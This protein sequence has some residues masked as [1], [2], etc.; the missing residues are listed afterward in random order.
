MGDKSSKRLPEVQPFDPSVQQSGHEAKALVASQLIYP[1]L[2]Q[3]WTKSLHQKASLNLRNLWSSII[4]RSDFRKCWER[5]WYR[6][7]YQKNGGRLGTSL[8]RT[9]K[10]ERYRHLYCRRQLH[11]WNATDPRWSDRQDTDHEGK[12]LCQNFLTKNQGLGRLVAL[13]LEFLRIL[14]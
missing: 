6:K 8:G 5:V 2:S 9:Q 11:R 7:D 10:M 4:V 3:A 13:H 14:G 1:F 12:P